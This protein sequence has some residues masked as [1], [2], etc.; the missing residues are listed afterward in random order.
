MVSPNLTRSNPIYFTSLDPFNYDATI[1]Q[2]E[3]HE[4][5]ITSV[6]FHP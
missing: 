4:G 3:L 6:Q 5:G 2:S 1:H